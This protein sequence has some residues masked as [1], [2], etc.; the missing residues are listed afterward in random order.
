MRTGADDLAV[1]VF[2]GVGTNVADSAAT[3]RGGSV[4]HLLGMVVGWVENVSGG[5]IRKVGRLALRVS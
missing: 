5:V 3:V 1:D 4:G 2:R